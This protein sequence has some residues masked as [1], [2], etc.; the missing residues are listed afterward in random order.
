MKISSLHV[1]PDL[2]LYHTGPSLDLGPLPSFFY[3]SLSGPDSLGLDPFNQPVQFLNGHMIRVF[4]LTL[5]GHENNL[6][7]TEAMEVWASDFQKGRNPIQTFLEG[8]DLAFDFALQN[9]LIDKAKV[10][11]GGLSRG[12]FMALHAAARQ[13]AIRYVACFAPLTKLS[14]IKE[15]SHF[16]KDP[17]I[18]SLN[19]ETLASQLVQKHVRLYIGN[20]DTRVGSKDC[21][22]FASSLVDAAIKHQIRSPKVAFLMYPSVG[23]QGHGTP[24]EIFRDGADWIRSCLTASS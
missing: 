13:D 18:D 24:P 16:Q 17:K 19:V 6:P 12:G 11:V 21:F 10:G 7:A 15:F 1:A 14:S 2:T 4:S 22:H 5:P 23:M 9:G 8:F 3:F 20:H